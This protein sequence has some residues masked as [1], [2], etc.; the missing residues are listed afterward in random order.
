M[1]WRTGITEKCQIAHHTIIALQ[2]EVSLSKRRCG[3]AGSVAQ[4]PGIS[5][6]GST[7]EWTPLLISDVA[8]DN[9]GSCCQLFLEIRTSW[10]YIQFLHS[11]PGRG[12][13]TTT[14]SPYRVLNLQ[15]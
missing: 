7:M 1:A 9:N 3:S 5:G 4:K 10:L 11:K 8:P 13:I 2:E 6:A 12:Y 14:C 15:N